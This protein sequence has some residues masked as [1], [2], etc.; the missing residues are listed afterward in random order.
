MAAP[1][2]RKIALI[3]GA[4]G[5]IGRATALALAKTGD[6]DLA[7][8]YNSAGEEARN[9]ISSTIKDA[10]G[11]SSIRIEFF[12]ADLGN[13]DSVRQLHKDV[14][15]KLGNV[16]VLFNN[17]GA[18]AGLKGVQ[19]LSEVPIDAFDQ[20]FKI[21]TGSGILLAQLCLPHMEE[22]GWGRI[23]FDSSAAAFTGGYVGPHYA[24]SKSAQH[25]FIH[26]LANNVAKKG[27]TVNGVAPALIGDTNMMGDS[28]DDEVLKRIAQSK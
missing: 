26:W 18:N 25:G 23:I 17:A 3:T 14:V 6:F 19:N 28:E 9:A 2:Q 7:L 5:G 22:K 12:Q 24:S 20:S 15:S 4:T 11:T 1:Q 21:N 8:H 13:Y 16:D 10:V 27:I